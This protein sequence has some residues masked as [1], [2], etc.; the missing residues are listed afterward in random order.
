[1]GLVRVVHCVPPAQ[2]HAFSLILYFLAWI[3]SLDIF[4]V[5]KCFILDVPVLNF[6]NSDVVTKKYR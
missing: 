3:F 2:L 6:R 5:F 4:C 1:M